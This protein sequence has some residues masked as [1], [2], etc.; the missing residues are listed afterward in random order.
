MPI[1]RNKE[2]LLGVTGGIAAYKCCELIRLLVKAG[3]RVQVVMT[4]AA[5]KFVSPITFQT[6][7]GNPVY[8][9]LFEKNANP[10]VH[11]ELADR[12][13]LLVV[14]PA[15]ANIIGKMANGIADDLLS[16]LYLATKARVLVCPAMNVNM[17]EHDAVQD[18][19]ACLK[20]RNAKVLEPGVGELA[21]G[22][23]GK[24]RLPDAD[25]IIE[26]CEYML[27]P[28]D[29]TDEK[30]YHRGSHPRGH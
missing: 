18:N 10:L 11:I 5:E 2:I 4:E 9:A 8:S 19:L 6:L 15:T 24:G 7:T 25:M 14:A 21:C 27:A 26:A 28:Q 29:F 12:A 3:A 1:L 13:E 30:Y 20:Q 16:T 23:E 17:Y 22:W